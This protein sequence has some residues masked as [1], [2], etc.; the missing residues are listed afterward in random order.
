MTGKPLR[1]AAE[2]HQQDDG[3]VAEVAEGAVPHAIHSEPAGTPPSTYTCAGRGCMCSR[4]CMHMHVLASNRRLVPVLED[5]HEWSTD[6][7]PS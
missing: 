2:L 6:Q 3:D 4:S 1:Q 7:L 5:I